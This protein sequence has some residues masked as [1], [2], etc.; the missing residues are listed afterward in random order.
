MLLDIALKPRYSLLDKY[1][2]DSKHL[3]GGFEAG[4]DCLSP[5]G[6]FKPKSLSI[7]NHALE[8]SSVLISPQLTR[9]YAVLCFYLW[10]FS[11]WAHLTFVRM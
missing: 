7:L 6:T 2:G 8:S 4:R 1:R 10:Y 3:C 9:Y 5:K 11:S